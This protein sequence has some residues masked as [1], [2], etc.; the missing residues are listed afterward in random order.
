MDSFGPGRKRYRSDA[1][2]QEN[3][4]G[5]TDGNRFKPFG[6]T[7]EKESLTTTLGSKTKAA[8]TKFFSTSGCPYGESCH[9]LHYVPGGVNAT[10]MANFGSG[11]GA[12]A[13]KNTGVLPS[14]QTFPP[15]SFKTRLCTKYDT[16]EGCR[17]AEKCHFAHGESELGKGN[18]DSYAVKNER[19]TDRFGSRLPTGFDGKVGGRAGYRDT[20]T[21][22]AATFGLSSTAKISVDA[23]LAGAIIGKGGVNSKQICRVT[24]VKLAIR[25]HESDDNLKNIELEGTFEQIQQASVMVRDLIM[26]T[27]TMAPPKQQSSYST[28][29]FKTK[30]CDNYAQGTCTFGDRCHFAHG[31]S[32]LQDHSKHA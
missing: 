14:D 27:S 11:L 28:N 4:G 20:T 15:A 12:T 23:S 19:T 7:P 26:H 31:N 3:G 8:C 22:A 24:G 5:Y 32:E 10:Q 29:N 25:D 30:L 17:F 9:F 13:K 18:A 6:A 1:F 21:P 2:L 16:A